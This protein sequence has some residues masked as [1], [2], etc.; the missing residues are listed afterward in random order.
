[1]KYKEALAIAMAEAMEDPS[2][3]LIGQ[4]VTDFK[5]DMGHHHWIAKKIPQARHWDSII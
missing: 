2:T 3:L 1:M 4:G 5:G